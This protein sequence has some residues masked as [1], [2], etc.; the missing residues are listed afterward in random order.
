LRLFCLFGL[1]I[2]AE[3]KKKLKTA[4]EVEQFPLAVTKEAGKECTC[5]SA[6]PDNLLVVI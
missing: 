4:A 2:Q 3:F 5:C 1:Q 6:F